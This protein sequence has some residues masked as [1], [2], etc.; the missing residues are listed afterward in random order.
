MT[1]SVSGALAKTAISPWDSINREIFAAT[2]PIVDDVSFSVN[3][4]D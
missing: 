1:V 2:E 4:T 3:T